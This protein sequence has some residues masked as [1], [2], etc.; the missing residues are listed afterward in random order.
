M[1]E[2]V[3]AIKRKRNLP[4]NFT[5]PSDTIE[6]R[7]QRNKLLNTHKGSGNILPLLPLEPQFLQIILKIARMRESLTPSKCVTLFNNM[8]DGTEYQSKLVEW[9]KKYTCE[10]DDQRLKEVGYK[11]WL[12]F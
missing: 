12:N 11:Y 10:T 7:I 8:I 1:Q 6:K 4:E 2:I 3:I 9:K 5:V